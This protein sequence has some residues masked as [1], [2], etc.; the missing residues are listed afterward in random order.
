MSE[1]KKLFISFRTAVV[2][3][4]IVILT[5][6]VLAAIATAIPSLGA[7]INLIA[8]V[9]TSGL[10]AAG[11]FYGAWHSRRYG[12]FVTIAWALLTIAQLSDTLGAVIKLVFY[13]NSQPIQY[14]SPADVIFLLFFPLLATGI[15]FLL[16][17]LFAPDERPKLLLDT[18]IIIL[19]SVQLAWAVV[20]GLTFAP[21]SP[22]HATELIGLTFTLIQ[23]MAIIILA[24]TTLKFII[25][26]PLSLIPKPFVL[27]MIGVAIEILTDIIFEY[28][29]SHRIYL[30]GGFTEVGWTVAYAMI[31][32]AG[33][34]HATMPRAQSKWAL[35]LSQLRYESS[36]WLHYTPLLWVV[37]GYF[38]I[39]W[40]R[41][42]PLPIDPSIL[43]WGM[44]GIV[45][46][47][48]VRQLLVMRENVRL[49]T[50]AQSELAERRRM[51]EALRRVNA[52]LTAA[53]QKL[54]ELDKMKDQFV[55][56]VSHELRTPQANIKLYLRLLER[57]KPE[58]YAEYMQTLHREVA[59]LEKMIDDLLD[60]SRLDRDVTPIEVIDSTIE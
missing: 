54:Q 37:I 49:R 19:G 30:R 26:W 4:V 45:V 13:S 17:A 38:V 10:A 3:A 41:S 22:S 35:S 29:T 31:G 21:T 50:A 18:G 51:E 2:I 42:H 46:L 16:A 43:E 11:L 5:H 32:L 59:R 28:Q 27:L 55:S 47:G 20:I 57:G 52:E 7:P 23:A 39:V 33:V 53:N 25:S 9:I 6:L 12:R 48:I 56:N 8:S 44:G 36:S 58:K 34:L 24:I 1:D 14:P 15:L 60:L 40:N